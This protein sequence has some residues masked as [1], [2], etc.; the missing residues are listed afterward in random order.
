MAAWARLKPSG[1]AEIFTGDTDI[2]GEDGTHYPR[3]IVYLWT[4]EELRA[5]GLLPL[6]RVAPPPG[7]VVVSIAHEEVNGT[8]TEVLTTEPAPPPPPDPDAELAAA[9]AAATTLEE[10]KAALLGQGNNSAV[11]GKRV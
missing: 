8:I 4:D 11:R 9:I 5:I 6:V 10:L 2:I 3:N 1:E 7:M